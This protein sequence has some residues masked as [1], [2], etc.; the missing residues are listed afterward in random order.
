MRGWDPEERKEGE[1]R[2]LWKERKAQ[3]PDVDGGFR[4]ALARNTPCGA[5]AEGL[6]TINLLISV[7]CF[8]GFDVT[9]AL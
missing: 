2:K 6:Q 8:L 1:V 7:S 3:P 9:T 4:R 5:V